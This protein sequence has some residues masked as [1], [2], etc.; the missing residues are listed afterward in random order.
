MVCVVVPRHNAIA[1]LPI[2]SI[3]YLVVFNTV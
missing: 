3:Q 1:V 2:T